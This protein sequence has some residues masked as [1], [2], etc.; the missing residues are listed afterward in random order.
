MDMMREFGAMA[1]ASRLRR[2][3][4][5]L[6]TEATKLYRANGIEFNDSWYLLAFMLSTRQGISVTEVAEA[7]G[8]SHAAISQMSTAMERKGLLVGQPDER[9]RRR[10]LLYLTEAGLSAVEA[11]RP[12]W[13]AI[14][15]ST[16]EL[17]SSTGQDILLAISEFE[18]HIEKRSLFSRVTERLNNDN[19]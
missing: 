1:F 10:T 15:E 2:L 4:D 3:G 11:L 8:V 6:K 13:D 19:S 17:I 14:G 12:I 16:V 7:F 18:E 5:R 9:D